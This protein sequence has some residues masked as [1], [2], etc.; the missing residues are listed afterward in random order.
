M[1]YFPTTIRE[2]S[3]QEFGNSFLH[4][5]PK[6]WTDIQI[7]NRKGQHAYISSLSLKRTGR[8]LPDEETLTCALALPTELHTSRCATLLLHSALNINATTFEDLLEDI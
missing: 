6:S 5:L 7:R 8:D 2:E 3:L 4:T 1:P